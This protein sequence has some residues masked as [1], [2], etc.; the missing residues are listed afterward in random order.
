[1]N[2]AAVNEL[3]RIEA[4]WAR[5]LVENDADAI[6][7]PM[8]D[9]WIL[10]DADGHVIDKARFL[11]AVKSGDLVHQVMEFDETTIRVY[12]NTAIVTQRAIVEG[13]YKGQAFSSRE[14]STD[15]F[16]R[17]EGSWR[18]VHTQ[19]TAIRTTEGG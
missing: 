2:A 18:C 19:L 4:E 12:K 3:T 8:V 9:D 5:A 14:R 15:V 16:V 10:I 13:T 6:A 1:M 17:L 11:A 7:R